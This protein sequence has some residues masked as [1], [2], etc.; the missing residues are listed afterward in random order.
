MG[1]TFWRNG[2]EA[3]V[4]EAGGRQS[5]GV[6]EAREMIGHWVLLRERGEYWL[7]VQM[8]MYHLTGVLRG[9]RLT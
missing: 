2:T 7:F 8:S 9:S 5:V 1:P 4:V 3:C 6:V